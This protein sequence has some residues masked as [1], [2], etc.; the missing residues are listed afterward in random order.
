MPYQYEPN[1][2]KSKLFSTCD[3]NRSLSLTFVNSVNICLQK[4]PSFFLC[5]AS[6]NKQLTEVTIAKQGG[7][8]IKAALDP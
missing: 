2:I 7:R 3:K 8:G 1:K 6:K 5:L 4:T